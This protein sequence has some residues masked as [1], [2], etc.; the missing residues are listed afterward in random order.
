MYFSKI[1][2]LSLFI[3]CTIIPNFSKSLLNACNTSIQILTF[4][5]THNHTLI[6]PSHKL[7][8]QRYIFHTAY[9]QNKL[10]PKQAQYT[11]TPAHLLRE[12]SK[13][14]NYKHLRTYLYYTDHKYTTT[15]ATSMPT[16]TISKSTYTHLYLPHLDQPQ[17]LQLHHRS[18]YPQSSIL[19]FNY[20]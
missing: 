15:L 11:N 13:Y 8:N 4:T 16:L 7:A 10:K 18:W 5:F 3:N 12:Y 14:P 2:V 17:T 19:S 6:P 9:A 1:F 20:E